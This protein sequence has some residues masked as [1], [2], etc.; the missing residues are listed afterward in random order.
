MQTSVRIRVDGWGWGRLKWRVGGGFVEVKEI[1]LE[2]W[3][4]ELEWEL[5]S[6]SLELLFEVKFETRVCGWETPWTRFWNRHG[7]ADI[8]SKVK[9]HTSALSLRRVPAF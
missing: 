4:L 6:P 1:G 7:S 2:M 3:T 9:V 5:R 8:N